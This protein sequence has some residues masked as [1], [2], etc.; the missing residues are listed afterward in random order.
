MNRIVDRYEGQNLLKYNYDK[1]RT[2]K[3]DVRDVISTVINLLQLTKGSNEYM[4]TMNTDSNHVSRIVKRIKMYY[5]YN[6]LGTKL[7]FADYEDKGRINI[8]IAVKMLNKEFKD[9]AIGEEVKTIVDFQSDKE[10]FD[11]KMFIH[12]F[13]E[14][15]KNKD[16]HNAENNGYEDDN[17]NENTFQSNITNEFKMKNNSTN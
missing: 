10:G 5:D 8:E 12:K 11:Y 4:D 14:Q 9:I 17:I 1:N 3:V 16:N 2:L 15:D 13:Y 7:E 6:G